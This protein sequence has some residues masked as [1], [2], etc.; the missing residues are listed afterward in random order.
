MRRSSAPLRALR[1]LICL[2]LIL[3][4]AGGLRAQPA[5]AGEGWLVICGAEG[6]Y[7]VPAPD[8]TDKPKTPGH[9]DC[10]V[11]AAGCCAGC[12]PAFAP[13]SATVVAAISVASASAFASVDRNVASAAE[14][15][16]QPRG[17][18]ARLPS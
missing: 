7:R 16:S 13:A 4:G 18:P 8:G 2:A 5:E 17:P 1:A 6:T 3:P 12:G 15:V 10:A 14:T 9:A 11:C